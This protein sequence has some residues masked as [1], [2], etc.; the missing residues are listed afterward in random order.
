MNDMKDMI[1]Q[2]FRYEKDT[3]EVSCTK[4]VK[5]CTYGTQI[6][7]KDTNIPKISVS[8]IY[9]NGNRQPD[10]MVDK[11]IEIY[12]D[13]DIEAKEKKFFSAG[14]VAVSHNDE[15]LAYSIDDKGSE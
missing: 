6:I 2:I 15:F 13:G 5:Y 1:Y 9:D 11:K 3:L 10:K 8:S 12:C 4:S 7:L 14:D